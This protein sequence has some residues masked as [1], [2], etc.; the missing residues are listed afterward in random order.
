MKEVIT[1]F[2][3]EYSGGSRIFVSQGLL[4][5]P[6]SI[7]LMFGGALWSTTGE[8]THTLAWL[9]TNGLELYLRT[10][11]NLVSSMVRVIK[12]HINVR[13]YNTVT[14]SFIASI[15]PQRQTF[16]PEWPNSLRAPSSCPQPPLLKHLHL[17]SSIYLSIQ[18]HLAFGF[19]Q[20]VSSGW[21]RLDFPWKYSEAPSAA[22]PRTL[23]WIP[24][25]ITKITISQMY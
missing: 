19:H 22:K 25:Y 23:L 16:H 11:D 21:C 2:H 18:A 6:L 3:T 13:A 8:P 5:G 17:S 15:N 24:H 9:Q 4:R 14:L 1:S 7:I 20:S 10:S 12:W